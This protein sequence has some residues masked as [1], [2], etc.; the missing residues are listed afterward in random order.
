MQGQEWRTSLSFGDGRPLRY[1]VLAFPCSRLPVF[2][3]SPRSCTGGTRI[4]P[5]QTTVSGIAPGDS[6]FRV[7]SACPS[8]TCS[9]RARRGRPPVRLEDLSPGFLDNFVYDRWP[10]SRGGLPSR[11]LRS[12]FPPRRRSIAGAP[13]SSTGFFNGG[14]RA[15][16]RVVNRR[17]PVVSPLCGPARQKNTPP[18]R[19]ESKVRRLQGTRSDTL[20]RGGRVECT[21]ASPS[22]VPLPPQA[23]APPLAS[24]GRQAGADVAGSPR[25]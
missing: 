10:V 11:T 15:T 16:G 17:V 13:C 25:W 14:M 19:E 8:R 6:P 9:P 4:A 5:A 24:I 21:P 23:A 1:R 2:S 3:S 20:T 22:P 7:T 12:T 18:A